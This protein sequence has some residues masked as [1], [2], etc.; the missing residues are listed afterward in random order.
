MALLMTLSLTSARSAILPAARI[1]AL[2]WL[3]LG[4]NLIGLPA[5]HAQD[6]QYISDK[7]MVPVRSG[8]GSE[9]RVSLI[10]I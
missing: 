1:S 3:L 8:A 7:V 9:F 6:T 4:V 2:I 5:A 10:H